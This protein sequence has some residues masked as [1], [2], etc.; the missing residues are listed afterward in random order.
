[1][2]QLIRYRPSASMVVALIALFI[3]TGGGAYAAITL[4]GGSVGGKQLKASAVTGG[5]LADGSVTGA[6]VKNHSL[7]AEDFK[8]G[9]LPAGPPGPTGAT[10]A[11]GA[12]G[13]PGAAGAPG[14]PATALWAVVDASGALVHGSHVTAAAKLF[15]G[16][17]AGAYEVTF[18]RD[19]SS[20]ALLATLGR[21]DAANANPAPGEIGT[22]Y[23]N[24]NPA[25]VFVKTLNSAGVEADG[26][27]HLAVFC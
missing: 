1:M 2:R 10:G 23:R 16:T 12:A 6:K 24:G 19:V 26:S 15:T 25:A 8:A 20:C 22:A 11:T 14:Q 27:F 13:S 21:T 17:V 9:Q 7:L 3:A 4:P 5:K 18:D